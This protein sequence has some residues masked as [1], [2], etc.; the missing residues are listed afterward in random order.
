MVPAVRDTI[1]V[2]KTMGRSLVIGGFADELYLGLPISKQPYRSTICAIPET[3]TEERNYYGAIA[4]SVDP[5]DT[6]NS[7]QDP[8]GCEPFYY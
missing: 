7:A 2:Y 5:V 3:G 8:F 1:V 4:D 6:V